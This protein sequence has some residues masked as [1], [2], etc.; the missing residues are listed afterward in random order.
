M[1]NLVKHIISK[2]QGGFVAGRQILDNIIIVQEAIH[3]NME[4]KQ[5]GMAI[6]IDMTNTFDRVNIFF[7]LKLFPGLAS[8]IGLLDGSKP[9]L[10]IC[11]L[12]R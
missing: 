5:Q 9:V 1:K 3:S 2:S 6:K 8:Q 12:L 4:R 10:T 11:G 7:F